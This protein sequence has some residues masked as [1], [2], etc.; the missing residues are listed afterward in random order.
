MCA[1]VKT[2]A[3]ERRDNHF[4]IS[5]SYRPRNNPRKRSSSMKAP[6]KEK[7]S[8]HGAHEMSLAVPR[9]LT[10]G[11]WRARTE[12]AAAPIKPK[13]RPSIKRPFRM[14]SDA[15]SSPQSFATARIPITISDDCKNL[16]TATPIGVWVVRPRNLSPGSA[17]KNPNE[18]P[19]TAVK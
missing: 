8:I 13:L 15:K 16:A 19:K 5:G 9:A 11:C 4:P 14:Y 3:V 18:D 7:S 6:D 17:K 2:K 1:K 10:A 12:Q